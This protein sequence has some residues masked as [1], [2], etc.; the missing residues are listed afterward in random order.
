VSGTVTPGRFADLLVVDGNPLTDIRNTRRI[1]AIVANGRFIDRAERE[2]MLAEV[3]AE[4]KRIP[5]PAV[6]HLGSC[7]TPLPTGS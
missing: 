3:V 6:Q 7:C 5:P 4:A 2:R 1:H